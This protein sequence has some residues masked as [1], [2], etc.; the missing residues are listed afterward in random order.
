M[1]LED[2]KTL[3]DYDQW[4]I[5]RVLEIVL[6][7]TE[8]QFNKDLGSSHGGVR[9]TMTHMYGGHRIWLDRWMGK[10]NLPLTK[11]E[12][13]RSV[14][15]L[16]TM[17]ET[18]RTELNTYLS[19][20]TNDRIQAPFTYKDMKGNAYTQ[21]LSEQLQHLVNHATYHRGQVITLLRQLGVKPLGTD[22]ILFY[23]KHAQ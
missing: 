13:I 12:D 2:I 9:G 23:Q 11:A 21:P 16:K 20:L 4:A 15:H 6:T 18:L 5:D 22:M 3:Y 8:E 17:W 1:N 10:E 19:S 14:G 7:L